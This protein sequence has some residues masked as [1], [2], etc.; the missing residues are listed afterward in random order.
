MELSKSI[1]FAYHGQKI[2]KSGSL[3]PSYDAFVRESNRKKMEADLLMDANSSDYATAM[4]GGK[5]VRRKPMGKFNLDQA[6]KN[7]HTSQGEGP[8]TFFLT[9]L[10]DEIRRISHEEYLASHR[11]EDAPGGLVKDETDLELISLLDRISRMKA[12]SNK[13]L[14][15]HR[16]KERNIEELENEVFTVEKNYI[17]LLFRL[18]LLFLFVDNTSSRIRYLLN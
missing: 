12:I 6:L 2:M 18:L 7:M 16:E 13:L 4:R 17:V 1:P 5:L 15:I 3:F 9:E 10:D 11:P 14:I 8:S